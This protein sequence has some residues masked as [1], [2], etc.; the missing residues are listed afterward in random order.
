E[1]AKLLLRESRSGISLIQQARKK[2]ARYEDEY[3][4]EQKSIEDEI[5]SQES[6]I[7]ELKRRAV[8]S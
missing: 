3:R 1:E 7:A 2:Q 6:D 8:G 5:K 4:N